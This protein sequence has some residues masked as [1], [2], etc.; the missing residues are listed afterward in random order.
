MLTG[1]GSVGTVG[2]RRAATSRFT[3]KVPNGKENLVRSSAATTL[4]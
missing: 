1:N 4:R 3:V 2:I